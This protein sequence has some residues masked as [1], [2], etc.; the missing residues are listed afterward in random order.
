MCPRFKIS[1]EYFFFFH[2]GWIDLVR[3]RTGT[4]DRPFRSRFQTCRSVHYFYFFLLF[5]YENIQKFYWV[6]TRSRKVYIRSVWWKFSTSILII[7]RQNWYQCK[8]QTG[9]SNFFRPIPSM[10]LVELHKKKCVSNYKK[11]FYKSQNLE[12]YFP[13]IWK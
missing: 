11:V 13:Y 9:R 4:D 12:I 7:K 6:S 5:S 10:Q 1:E 3:D 2:N 8:S